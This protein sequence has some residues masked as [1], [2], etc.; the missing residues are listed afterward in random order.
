MTI[1]AQP[2]KTFGEFAA[3]CGDCSKLHTVF[4]AAHRLIPYI[5]KHFW[6]CLKLDF[7]YKIQIQD[8]NSEN[9]YHFHDNIGESSKFPKSWA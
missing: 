1:K 7:Q 3:D 2:Q 6:V 8:S 4:Q 9:L 5:K